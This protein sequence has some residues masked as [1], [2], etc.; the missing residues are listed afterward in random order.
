AWPKYILPGGRYYI[1][2]GTSMAAPHVT[3]ACALLLSMN[4]VLTSVR[5]KE[6]LQASALKDRFTEVR[7]GN[8]WGAGKMDIARAASMV[9]SSSSTFSRSMLQYDSGFVSTDL[10]LSGSMKAAIRLTPAQ[11][12]ALT[13]AVIRTVPSA[14]GTVSAK[15]DFML[16]LYADAAGAPGAQIGSAVRLHCSTLNA[17]TYNYI[18]LI[19]AGMMVEK[20]REYFFTLSL[21]DTCDTLAIQSDKAVP[22]AHSLLYDGGG[23]KAAANNLRI[24]AELASYDNVTAVVDGGSIV[25]QTFSLE[26]NYPNPFNPSTSIGYSLPAKSHVTLTISDMLGKVVATLVKGE[27]EAGFHRVTW[28][29][30]TS[31]GFSAASGM[32]FYR[33][34]SNGR[35]LCRKML[36]VK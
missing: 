15:G 24:R 21:A 28:N 33:I 8:F 30:R 35:Q 13:Q 31:A 5:I 6:I 23:W 29:G 19:G 17:G 1:N 36:L 16:H 22:T 14:D 4:P 12:G 25:P 18:P 3:G 10:S 9:L 26:Q 11:S 32:Y 7:S 20:N 34:E 27:E 2:S